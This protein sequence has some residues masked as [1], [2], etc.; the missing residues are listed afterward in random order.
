M[1][2]VEMYKRIAKKDDSK[3]KKFDDRSRTT[4][5][6]IVF[7]EANRVYQEEGLADVQTKFTGKYCRSV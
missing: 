1:T 2:A 5:D 4:T 7:N 3:E 6:R